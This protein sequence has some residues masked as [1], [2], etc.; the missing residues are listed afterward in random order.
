MTGEAI[1]PVW[2]D[3]WPL[4]FFAGRGAVAWF[5]YQ[6]LI[7]AD[8]TRL[9]AYRHWC[10]GGHYLYLEEDGRHAWGW[11][12][13]ES[14]LYFR[15][16]RGVDALQGG[17]PSWWLESCAEPDEIAAYETAIAYIRDAPARRARAAALND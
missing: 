5:E 10:T 14:E 16:A 2:P 12:Y 15:Y 3:P 1:D 17:W 7:L 4:T 6:P 13:P 11:R 8:R 9:Q